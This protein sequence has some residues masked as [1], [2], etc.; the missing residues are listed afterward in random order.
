[1]FT[2]GYLCSKNIHIQCKTYNEKFSYLLAEKK[3]ILRSL[4]TNL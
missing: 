3:G 2:Y 1:M 4:L